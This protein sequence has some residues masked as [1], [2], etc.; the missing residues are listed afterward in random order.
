ML[1]ASATQALRLLVL[2]LYL[3]LG[4][5][6][7]RNHSFDQVIQKLRID[8][9]IALTNMRN[10]VAKFNQIHSQISGQLL[11]LYASNSII[12]T[13]EDPILQ[14]PLEYLLRQKRRRRI[15]EDKD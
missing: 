3:I 8:D 2:L 10:L 6:E 4:D 7:C 1:T 5:D 13:P 12:R 9:Q 14:N 11:V 15:D